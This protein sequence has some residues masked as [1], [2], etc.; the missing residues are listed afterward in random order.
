MLW[1]FEREGRRTTVEVL[2]LPHAAYELRVVD[3]D[4]TEHI[5]HF[6]S[7]QDL[8]KRQRAIHDNLLAQG[9]THSGGWR[10]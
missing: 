3:A 5:E 10:I 7:P 4:G 8:A 1:W 2:E 6:T 9:W